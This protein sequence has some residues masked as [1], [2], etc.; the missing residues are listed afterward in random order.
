M[1]YDFVK[2]VHCI[3]C[4]ESNK[5]NTHSIWASQF[6]QGPA[7]P[8]FRPQVAC[9]HWSLLETLET[10]SPHQIY[11]NSTEKSGVQERKEQNTEIQEIS[12]VKI[13]FGTKDYKN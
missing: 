4:I 12:L 8:W 5:K 3:V 9:Q 10:D 7:N 13:V 2:Y 11:W 6:V 1:L